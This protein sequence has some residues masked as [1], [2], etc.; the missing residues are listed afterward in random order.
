MHPAVKNKRGRKGLTPRCLPFSLHPNRMAALP[1]KTKGLRRS[2]IRPAHTS[3]PSGA[4]GESDRR[5]SSVRKAP[6]AIAR[7]AACP[8]TRPREPTG[9]KHLAAASRTAFRWR[10]RNPGAPPAPPRAALGQAGH[11]ERPPSGSPGFRAK[12]R[13]PQG[14]RCITNPPAGPRL[15]APEGRPRP[16]AHFFPAHGPHQGVVWPRHRF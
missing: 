13:A 9:A 2:A 12:A 7:L 11:W 10:H 15:Q 4:T 16:P 8:R 1:A 3:G 6:R 5:E 14:E